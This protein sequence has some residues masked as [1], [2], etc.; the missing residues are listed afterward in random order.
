[1]KILIQN[2]L[3]LLY[4]ESGWRCAKKDIRIDGNRIEAVGE[5]LSA[6]GCE[7][8]DASGKLAMPGLINAHTHAYMTIHRNYAD[9]LMF[10]D[11]LD[12]VQRVEDGMTEEDVY[13]TTLLGIIEMI[14]TGTTCFVDM[15]IKSAQEKT[16]PRSAAAGRRR[17]SHYE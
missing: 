2:G 1:M 8:I 15:T 9:D 6:E 14:R 13:W 5:N 4:G 12:K 10:F 17:R 3:A 11:W 16:G 7:I